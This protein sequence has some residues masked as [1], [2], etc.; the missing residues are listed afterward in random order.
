[1]TY[2]FSFDLY[3]IFTL[4]GYKI[5]ILAFFVLN[6]LK[7]K[8]EKE[9]DGEG[10]TRHENLSS[11]QLLTLFVN[12]LKESSFFYFCQVNRWTIRKREWI[13]QVVKFWNTITE[14]DFSNL[15][16]TEVRQE[17]LNS[18]PSESTVFHVFFIT[19]YSGI[20]IIYSS[21]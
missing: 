14:K 20:R 9:N 12:S 11:G 15:S 4:I 18:K 6:E 13:A 19:S 21:S 7:G 8:L 5:Y 17:Q 2:I 16:E 1:M 3:K 10:T